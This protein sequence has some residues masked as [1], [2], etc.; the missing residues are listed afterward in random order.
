[1]TTHLRQGSA[2]AGLVLLAALS[3]SGCDRL[4]SDAP[5]PTDPEHTL[6]KPRAQPDTPNTEAPAL[7]AS[8]ASP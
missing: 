3:L 8:Q 2:V 4:P 1:M 6:P 5:R 7:P